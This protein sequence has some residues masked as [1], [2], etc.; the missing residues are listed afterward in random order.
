M[1]LFKVVIKYL[2][3]KVVDN[4]AIKEYFKFFVNWII[5]K[6][7]LIKIIFMDVEVMYVF[8]V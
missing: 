5:L 8:M 3:E 1:D 6:Y 7:E 4:E 2:M